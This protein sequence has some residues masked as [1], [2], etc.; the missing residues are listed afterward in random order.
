[1]CRSES[2]YPYILHLAHWLNLTGRGNSQFTLKGLAEDPPQ[3]SFTYFKLR[4][5]VDILK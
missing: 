5:R 2:L 1:M 3:T 4:E